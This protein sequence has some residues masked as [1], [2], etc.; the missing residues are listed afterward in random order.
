MR[1]DGA[2]INWRTV[3]LLIIVVNVPFWVLAFFTLDQTRQALNNQLASDFRAIAR[4]NAV[5]INYGI[6][7][8]VMKIGTLAISPDIRDV[9][10]RQNATYGSTS[11][12][13][14]NKISSIDK[15]WLTPAANSIV[16]QMLANPA[17]KFLRRFVE[18]NPGVK[19]VTVTDRFGGVAAA[20]V[21]TVDYEQSDEA[22]WQ[23]AFKDGISGTVV[24]E[25]VTL[26]PITKFNA[27]HVVVPI[28]EE[29]KDQVIGLIG[30]LIDISDLFPLVAG[31]KIGSTGET[32]LV[33]DQGSIIAGTEVMLRQQNQ[34]P[35][36]DDIRNAMHISTR[37]DFILVSAPGGKKTY[38]AYADT[39]LSVA[40]PALKWMVVA[41]QD[42]SEANGPLDALTRKFLWAALANLLVVTGISLYLFT[43]RRMRFLDLRQTRVE[44]D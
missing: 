33:T 40:Y 22:W 16:E 36:F 5:T 6:N 13:I 32:L 25:D 1:E 30:A 38:L 42:E 23:N 27:I 8:L 2:S 26:D 15:A 39:G 21:K 28:Q 4:R 17:S 11:E 9:V 12:G 19:R 10:H 14:R 37:P 29:G 44:E 31:V 43:H 20:N 3:I 7:H 24:I 34:L 18:I 35:Y 41:A